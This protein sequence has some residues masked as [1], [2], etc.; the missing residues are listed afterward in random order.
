MSSLID[1]KAEELIAVG[2]AY[3]LNCIKCMKVHRKAALDAG[4]SKEEM[5]E[6]LSVA[7]GVVSGARGVT[8][9]EAENIFGNKVSENRCCPEGS[10]CCA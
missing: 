6:A 7:E 9:K 2:A 1:K 5:N 3:A 10:E 8:K 4:A